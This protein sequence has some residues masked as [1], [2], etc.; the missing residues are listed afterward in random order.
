MKQPEGLKQTE[1]RRRSSVQHLL[2]PTDL[3]EDAGSGS[4]SAVHHTVEDGE[5]AVQRERLRAQEVVAR[6]KRRRVK[7]E[8]IILST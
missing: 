2:L 7:L 3:R 6:L 1:D 4:H 8:I 5:Q